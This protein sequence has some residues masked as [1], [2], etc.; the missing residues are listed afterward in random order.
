MKRRIAAAFDTAR[1]AELTSDGALVLFVAM[2]AVNGVNFVFNVVMSRMLGAA[3]YGAL[4]SLL[5]MVSVVTVVVGGLQLAVTQAVAEREATARSRVVAG[6]AF[7]AAG[8]VGL[9]V[10]A[11]TGALSP[12]LSSFLH[13]SSLVPVVLLALYL[14]PSIA[15]LVPQGVLIGERR[16]R[17]VA[18]ATLIGT[19]ARLVVG[20][21]LVGLGMGIDGAL[22]AS[23]ASAVLMLGMLAWP[24]RRQL[25]MREGAANLGVRLGP[26]ALS[27][28]GLGGFALFTMIDSLLARH[29]LPALQAGYYVAGATAAR[30]SL[31]LPGAVGVIAF[32]RLAAARAAGSDPTKVL[33]QSLGLIAVLGGLAALVMAALP[34]LVV[35]VVFG[36]AYAP[37]APVVRVLGIAAAAMAV[38]GQLVYVHVARHSRVATGCW[39]GAAGAVVLIAAFHGSPLSLAWAMLVLAGGLVV[40]M[41]VPALRRHEAAGELADLGPST[42]ELWAVD[43]PALDLS[44]VVP[45]YNPGPRLCP[46]LR[47]LCEVLERSDV[48]YEIIAVSD[49]STD[50]CDEALEALSPHI[51]C[52]RL[53]RNWGKGQALRVGLSM[54][55]GAYLGFIDADGDLPAGQVAS[56]VSLLRSHDPDVVLGSKRHPMSE[57]AY[58]PLRRLYSWGFQQLVR[59]LFHLEVRD[60]QTGLKIVRREV[61]ADVLARMVEKR[62]AFDLEL[63]VVARRLGYRRFFEAPVRIDER[64]TSTISTRAVWLTLLDTFAIFYRLRVLRWYDQVPTTLGLSELG[65][66]EIATFGIAPLAEGIRS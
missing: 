24:L 66:D 2:M 51:R 32:P 62:F 40:V 41:L 5:G 38:I 1:R 48:S 53:E 19:T 3:H 55:R 46:N 16:F 56:F 25:G 17:A 44:F 63:L 65:A 26:A 52:V 43:A 20:V 31:F 10:L 7:L 57:V 29:Y 6:K 30:I 61:L 15:G 60:T 47:A 27:L 35:S 49:G 22:L 59:L 28:V 34:G 64:L 18:A 42:G 13:L 45:Y 54:G 39:A 50:G 14:A 23:V 12:L 11:V 8:V 36:P 58:P 37:A 21:A 4:G 33:R 9:V